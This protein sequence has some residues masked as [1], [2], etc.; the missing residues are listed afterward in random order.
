V[1]S[2]LPEDVACPVVPI[3]DVQESLSDDPELAED[4]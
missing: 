2:V 1:P 3:E 4:V